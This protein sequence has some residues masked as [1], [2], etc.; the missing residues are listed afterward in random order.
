MAGHA[1]GCAFHPHRSLKRLVASALALAAAC[2]LAGGSLAAPTPA[3]A[4]T[5]EK[6]SA[7]PNKDSGNGV[8]G[9]EETRVTWE[10]QADPDEELTG[11]SLTFPADTAYGT[12]DLRVTMLSGEDLMDREFIRPKV[13]QDGQKL[14]V[15]FPEPAPAGRY[16]RLEVYGV[17]FPVAGGDQV[18]EGTYSLADGSEHDAKD[19][20]TI[21]I[22]KTGLVEQAQSFLEGQPWVEAWNSNMFLRLFLNPILIVSSMPIVFAGFLMSLKIVLV[23]FPLAIPFGF[24]LAIMRISKS[25]ILRLLASVYVNII[26]GT[27]AF[28]QIYIAFFGLPLAGVNIGNY[29]MGVIV[30]AM[31]ST[32]YLCEIFRAGIQSIPKGQN[33]AARSLGMNAFQTMVSIIVPQTFRNVIPTLTSEFILL[34][35]DTS[36]LAAVGVMEIV[37]GAQGVVATTGSITPYVV[38]ALFYLVITLPLARVVSKL[39]QRLMGADAGRGKKKSHKGSTAMASSPDQIAGL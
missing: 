15:S 1:E 24:C 8:I 14:E 29:E 12:D 32:A 31:N 39:E 6:L 26:R 37:K 3:A 16:F 5:V 13:K 28:L 21:A 23:A 18:F 10:L 22:E 4:A 36:L 11:L 2:I 27:P 38:A 7:Q 33:E 35:K 34:Y 19:M 9:G 20:P 30:M 17:N 25:R